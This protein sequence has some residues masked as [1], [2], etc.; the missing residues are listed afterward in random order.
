MPVLVVPCGFCACFINFGNFAS[1]IP[2]LDCRIVD[3]F[4]S[5]TGS[6]ISSSSQCQVVADL[7]SHKMTAKLCNTSKAMFPC[8]QVKLAVQRM[9]VPHF[10]D[11]L[12]VLS[13]RRVRGI[14]DEVRVVKSP[15]SSQQ[16]SYELLFGCSALL[17]VGPSH[18]QSL[19]VSYQFVGSPKKNHNRIITKSSY[20]LPQN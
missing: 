11:T 13:A 6:K 8:H 12:F 1:V 17:G 20:F 15:L 14:R 4:A 16:G 7:A 5:Q 9:V 10:R 3:L 18:A 2:L 19:S